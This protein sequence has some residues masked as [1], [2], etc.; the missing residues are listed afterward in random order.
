MNVELEINRVSKHYINLI[1]GYPKQAEHLVPC[2]II[3]G[4]ITSVS[5]KNSLLVILGQVKY[6][7]K[8]LML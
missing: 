4:R 3:N 8:C 2:D 7:I 6:I 1:N 5:N